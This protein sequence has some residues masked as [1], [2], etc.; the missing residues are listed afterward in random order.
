MRPSDMAG[1]AAAWWRTGLW[2]GILTLMTG[3]LRISL[4]RTSPPGVV[5]VFMWAGGRWCN[6]A[7]GRRS[8]RSC[9]TVC[10]CSPLQTGAPGRPEPAAWRRA[11][12]GGRRLVEPG[13][14]GVSVGKSPSSWRLVVRL[15]LPVDRPPPAATNRS[16]VNHLC[17]DT[18][19]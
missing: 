6:A 4:R 14:R 16:K 11:G 2:V 15:S 18:Y 9:W 10:S 13:R 17:P 7:S 19:N 3:P 8:G 1:G 5:A 12:E